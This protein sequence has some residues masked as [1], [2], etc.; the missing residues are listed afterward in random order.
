MAKFHGSLSYF[1]LQDAGGTVRNLS[2]H[3][4]DIDGLPGNIDIA[5]VTGMGGSTSRS[6]I[7]GLKDAKISLKG[8][9]DDTAS[10]GSDAVLSGIYAMATPAART[11]AYGPK[12]NTTGFPKYSGSAFL[13]NYT[14]RS[15][16]DSRVEFTAELDVSGGVTIGVF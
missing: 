6:K 9:F 15:G 7:G 11:F 8:T 16:V 1:E 5:D 3:I 2:A 14:L 10:T 12:G 4:T 13:S